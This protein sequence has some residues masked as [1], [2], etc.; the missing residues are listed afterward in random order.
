MIEDFA[1]MAYAYRHHPATATAPSAL[2]ETRAPPGMDPAAPFALKCLLDG[3]SGTAER[4]DQMSPTTTAASRR[5]AAQVASNSTLRLIAI[6]TT[7]QLFR[8]RL[9]CGDLPVL[10]R[11]RNGSKALKPPAWFAISQ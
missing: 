2:A 4:H 5:N 1:V 11:G 9:V 8:M 10:P 7:F 3:Q 6:R